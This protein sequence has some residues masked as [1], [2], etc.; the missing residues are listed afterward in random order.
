[1]SAVVVWSLT[2]LGSSAPMRKDEQR[3]AKRADSAIEKELRG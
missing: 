2:N 3:T 1:V